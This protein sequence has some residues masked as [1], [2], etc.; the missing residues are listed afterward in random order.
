MFDSILNLPSQ[1]LLYL[2]NKIKSTYLTL[3]PIKQ[4]P[5]M[6]TEQYEAIYPYVAGMLYQKLSFTSYCSTLIHFEDD[7][8]MEYEVNGIKLN[9][10][11]ITEHHNAKTHIF[12]FTYEGIWFYNNEPLDTSTYIQEY[13][14]RLVCNSHECLI[15]N[16]SITKENIDMDNIERL[17][18]EIGGMELPYEELFVYLEEEGIN[19]DAIY[20]A[21][22]K[23]NKKTIYST[24]LAI[25]NSI[26]NQPHLM[27]NYRQDDMTIDSF[28]KYLQARIDQLEKKIRQMPIEDSAPSN[29]FNLFQ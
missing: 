22:S 13:I 10:F 7:E 12:V 6:T 24:A 27:K 14:N 8:N 3:N 28:A 4:R 11:Y 18:M 9:G 20:N 23:A 26:A 16:K 2:E 19:G 17:Q 15:Y 21:S 25:L 1:S 29:F 5:L